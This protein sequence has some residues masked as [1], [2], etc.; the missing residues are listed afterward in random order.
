MSITFT[1]NNNSDDDDY[2]YL[3]ISIG[4]INSLI[5]LMDFRCMDR[6]SLTIL[7]INIP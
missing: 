1:F 7:H 5:K 4:V 3:Y 2:G 6:K